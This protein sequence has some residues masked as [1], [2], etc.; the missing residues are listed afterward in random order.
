NTA[1]AMKARG[2]SSDQREEQQMSKIKSGGGLT[3]NK[4]VRPE[5][6][7]G[8]ASRA[9]LPER[10]AQIGAATSF[11][12]PKLEGPGYD[13]AKFGNELALNV[14]AGGPG[15][16]RQVQHCGSQGTHGNVNPGNVRPRQG[17]E[18]TDFGPDIPG[19]NYKP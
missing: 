13:G 12:K 14:G 11:P 10:V 2:Q 3:S 9:M 18:I 4:L 1:Q 5:V 7:T 19:R 16:G 15:K 17:Y 6:R 8:S